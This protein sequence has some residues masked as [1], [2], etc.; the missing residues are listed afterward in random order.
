MEN[1]LKEKTKSIDE[2][3]FELL[4][5]VLSGNSNDPMSDLIRLQFAERLLTKKENTDKEEDIDSKI[6]GKAFTFAMLN[7]LFQPKEQQKPDL[8]PLL[9]FMNKDKGNDDFM[10][11]MQLYLQ[12][13]AQAQQ[14]QMQM[15]QQLFTMLFGK[16]KEDFNKN[17]ENLAKE[18]NKKLEDINYM[19]ASMQDRAERE[20]KLKKYVNELIETKQALEEL[21]DQLGLEKEVPV[22]DEKG[23]VNVGKLLER[24]IKLAEKVIEKMPARAPQ[25]QPVYEIPTPKNQPELVPEVQQPNPEEQKYEELEKKLENL[26]KK[27]E[28]VQFN[29]PETNINEEKTNINEVEQSGGGNESEEVTSESAGE[30]ETS[31]EIDTTGTEAG[32]EQGPEE[33]NREE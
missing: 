9:L 33:S 3:K 2:K 21:R 8:T 1:L 27:T 26:E 29:I 10:K 24:G 23:K 7:T 32:E 30:Q 13:Q 6:L 16:Q 14:M 22:T 17:I 12:Q 18:F 5:Q 25:P 31:D 19:I 4:Q 15:Q 11:F 28:E 20:P